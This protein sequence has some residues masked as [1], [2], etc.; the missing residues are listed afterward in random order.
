MLVPTFSGRTA[1]T[2][3]RLRPRR[4]IIALTHRPAVARHLALEWGVTPVVIPEGHDVVDLWSRSLDGARGT[5]IVDTGDLRRHHGG[6]RR[7]H[8]R[9]HERHQGRAAPEAQAGRRRRRR[10]R[11][12]AWL[13]A[14]HPGALVSRGAVCLGLRCRGWPP[15]CSCWSP[16]STTGRSRPTSTRARTVRER[17]AEVRALRARQQA[18]RGGFRP[19]RARLALAR[20]ARQLGFVK[21]G[22]APL[23]RRRH[24]ALA[25]RIR[26]RR[27]S[28][29]PAAYDRG[30]DDRAVVAQPARPTAARVPAASPRAARTGS[31]R[32]PSRRRTTTEGAPFP[33]T[34]Y[35]TCPHL[36]AAVSRLE[37]AAASS[38]GAN[39]WRGRSG[40]SCEPRAGDRA[41]QRA[42]RRGSPGEQAAPTT[43]P[44]SSSASAAPRDP[45]GS[46]ACTPTRPAR[47][48]DPELRA[49]PGDPARRSNDPWPAEG[50]CTDDHGS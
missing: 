34:Y 2:V 9:H 21:P 6:N 8:A 44:R 45:S 43:V 16:S 18:L 24:R 20:E 23:H 49:R 27:A 46:S 17:T 38:A 31:R 4:P 42:L 15:G 32:S 36:V 25:T 7:E 48:L 33:T 28:G 41:Q 39:A 26:P 47:S 13:P 5:G 3:A 10:E 50:C 37:A 14:A 40:V 12:R 1:S 35:L 11:W 30:V 19:C 22:R 29:A